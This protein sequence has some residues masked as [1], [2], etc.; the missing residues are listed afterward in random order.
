MAT[1]EEIIYNTAPVWKDEA[2]MPLQ[3]KDFSAAQTTL[4]KILSQKTLEEWA[5]VD[6]V[7]LI[8]GVPAFRGELEE[9]DWKQQF[10]PLILQSIFEIITP[11]IIA[12]I[13]NNVP[14]ETQKALHNYI[15][16]YINQQAKKAGMP[17]EEW[18]NNKKPSLYRYLKTNLAQDLGITL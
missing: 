11:D 3:N 14:A 2:W 12:Y 16:Q 13:Y 4:Q 18:L 17:S 10:Q 7:S 5:L 1:L 15:L 9:N 6:W 8:N